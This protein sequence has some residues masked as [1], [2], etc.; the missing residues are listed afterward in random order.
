M[1]EVTKNIEKDYQ[2]AALQLIEEVSKKDPFYPCTQKPISKE[3]L[4]VK[5][6]LLKSWP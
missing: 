1:E 6:E 2:G 3:Y 5:K 4:K